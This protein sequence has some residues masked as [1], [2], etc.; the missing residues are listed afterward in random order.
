MIVMK[1]QREMKES[2][3]IGQQMAD[4]VYRMQEEGR[5]GESKEQYEQRIYAKIESGQKLTPDELNYLA[6]TN[7]IM[8][9]KAL[10]AQ[11]M[12]KSL[13]NQLKSCSSKQEA[14]AVFSAAMSSI[15][16]KDPD[17]EIIVAALTQAYKEFRESA[18]Y[19]K[20]PQTEEEAQKTGGRDGIEMSVNESGYQEVYLPETGKNSFVINV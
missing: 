20:L 8:Y 15:S 5:R 2:K 16:E 9:Q 14:D 11:M 6:R 17:R 10:R 13:E 1:E 7:P 19:K 12:R 4:Y 18:A 3:T